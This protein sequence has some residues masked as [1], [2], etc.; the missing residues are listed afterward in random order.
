MF[1]RVLRSKCV[2][3]GIDAIVPVSEEVFWLAAAADSLPPSVSIRTSPLAILAGLHDKGRFAALATEL[4]FG[5]AENILLNSI[6]DV[7]S[8]S[9]PEKFVFKPVFSR[10]ASRVL[11]RPKRSWLKRVRPTRDQPWLAQTFVAGRELCAYNVAERGRLLLHVA[12]EPTYRIGSGAGVYFSPVVSETLRLMCERFISAT[13]FT[14]Q[15]SFDAIDTGARLVALECNPRG[16]S[17]V[18]L[19][20]QDPQALSET[21]L[22]QFGS[23]ARSLKAQPR[24]L[25]APLLLKNPMVLLSRSGRRRI[26]DARDALANAGIRPGRQAAAFAEIAWRALRSG[27]SLT[28]STTADIEWN[29][30]MVDR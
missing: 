30:E 25:L 14:G 10:F 2:E 21:L 13:G 27:I 20:A 16:T 28:E 18:H 24:M 4:G 19:A 23:A 7:T 15:I 8:I 22:G 1:Q 11:I 29:G 12:Y 26:R 17:G 3:M 5:A 6:A 9:E